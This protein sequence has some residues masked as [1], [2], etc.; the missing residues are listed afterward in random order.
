MYRNGAFCL[1][2]N[3][4]PNDV[5]VDENSFL[6]DIV[7]VV[8]N[9][10]FRKEELS[11]ESASILREKFDLFLENLVENS[12]QENN[13]IF[14]SQSSQVSR[15]DSRVPDGFHE[16]MNYQPLKKRRYTDH[17]GRE[18]ANSDDETHSGSDTEP[19]E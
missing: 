10:V 9:E 15:D 19:N 2:K 5:K 11:S 16:V 6:G 14:P 8:K 1:P 7:S 17:K 18:R 13:K 3:I 4:N 12:K